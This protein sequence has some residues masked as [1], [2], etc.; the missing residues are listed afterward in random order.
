MED[1]NSKKMFSL[2]CETA[3]FLPPVTG[4]DICL[5][6]A[7]ISNHVEAVVPKG[8]NAWELLLRSED[9]ANALELKGLSI[10][11]R[12]IEVSQRFPGGTWVRVRGLPLNAEDR[13]VWRIFQNFGEVVSGPHHVTWRGTPL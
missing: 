9:V 2:F 12:N 7:G 3:G 5:G 13:E 4:E 10:R 8:R 6:L 1:G 11:G